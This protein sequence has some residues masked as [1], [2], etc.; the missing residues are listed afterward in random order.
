MSGRAL[1][2]HGA[3]SDDVRTI[4]TAFVRER[5]AEGRRVV[6]V[7]EE[8]S[9]TGSGCAAGVLRNIASGEL[10][11]MSLDEA[12]DDT[13]CTL[14]ASGLAAAGEAVLRD[15]AAGY[16][17]VVLSKFGKVEAG[18]G[19]LFAAFAAAIAARA[20]LLTTVGDHHV[21]AWLRLAAPTTAV[22]APEKE[23]IEGW[24]RSI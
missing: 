2:L 11:R 9:D 13:S 17:V 8:R 4:L 22:A 20:P 12:P 3:S 1:A 14:D 24:W 23:S 6:G 16:D 15:M 5:K 21:D 19:G 7:F 18:G 10:F